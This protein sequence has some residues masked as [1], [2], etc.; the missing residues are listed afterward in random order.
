MA[1]ASGPPGTSQYALSKAAAWNT[2]AYFFT[3]DTNNDGPIGFYNHGWN[4]IVATG[5]PTAASPGNHDCN[6]EDGYCVSRLASNFDEYVGYSQ[7]SGKA[8]GPVQAFSGVGNDIGAY[9]DVDLKSHSNYAIRFS[10]NG[11]KFLVIALEVYPRFSVMTWAANLCAVYR[12]HQIIYLTHGYIHYLNRPCV[13][14]DTY[15]G[16]RGST[17]NG[18]YNVFPSSGQELY[19]NLIKLQ[20]NSFLTVSGHF[21]DPIPRVYGHYFSKGTHGNDIYAFYEDYQS[22]LLHN[23]AVVRISFHE[24]SKTFDVIIMSAQTDTVYT[25]WMN[26]PWPQ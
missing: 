7:S 19:D 10:V 8:W 5:L 21:P 24:H 3:G 9:N 20:P 17:G 6:I 23:D 16:G 2:K 22:Y 1:T 13:S 18:A 11:H 12:D 25:S 4:N 14:S 26:L 15:C